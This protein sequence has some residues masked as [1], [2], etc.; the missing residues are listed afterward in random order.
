LNGFNLKKN[1]TDKTYL[2]NIKKH[3]GLI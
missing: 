1:E 2:I 3:K